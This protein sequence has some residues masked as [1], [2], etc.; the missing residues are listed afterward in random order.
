MLAMA[1]GTTVQFRQT[2]HKVMVVALDAIVHAKV[3]NLQV[4]RYIV[5]IHEFLGIT[6]SG[7]EEQHIDFVQRK[8]V[9][10]DQISLTIQT[11]VNIRNLITCVTTTIDKFYFD[12][13][14]I[15]QQTNQFA[16]CIT[17]PTDNS[18]LNHNQMFS[19][20]SLWFA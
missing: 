2:I 6:M 14:V 8:F 5:A 16:C 18:Y 20:S 11:F 13:R 15:N 3:D 19:F 4:F 10:K 7:T 12:F 9:S 1:D 17:C